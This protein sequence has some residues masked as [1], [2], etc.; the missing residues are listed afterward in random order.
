MFTEDGV[1]AKARWIVTAL[2][3]AAAVCGPAVGE[4]VSVL[5]EEGAYAQEVVGDLDRAIGIYRKVIEGEEGNRRYLAE[6]RYRL[7]RCYLAKGGKDQAREQFRKLVELYP[8]QKAF[9]KAARDELAKLAPAEAAGTYTFG[10]VTD[11]TVNDD[12]AG[13]DFFMDLD[14]GRLFS[15]P[16]GLDLH[17]T[18]AMRRWVREN[19][20]DAMG[21]T[22]TSVHGLVGIEMVAFPFA[23]PRWDSVTA[24]QLI[25]DQ[26]LGAAQPNSLVPISAKGDLPATYIFKTREGGTGILQIVGFSSDP[27]G[28]KIRYK[29]VQKVEAVAGAYGGE[30]AM[31]GAGRGTTGASLTSVAVHPYLPLH[32]TVDRWLIP[33]TGLDLQTGTILPY[34][35]RTPDT[36]WYRPPETEVESFRPIG[37]PLRAV[38]ADLVW[39]R[40]SYGLKKQTDLQRPLIWKQSPISREVAEALQEDVE[41]M[42]EHA[43]VGRA[44]EILNQVTPLQIVHLGR[45]DAGRSV[46]I[47]LDVRTAPAKALDYICDLAGL[48]WKADGSLVWIGTP[49]RIEHLAIVHGPDV[50]PTSEATEALGQP[51][52]L[53]LQSTPLEQVAEFLSHMTPVKVHLL[54]GAQALGRERSEVTIRADLPLAEALDAVCRLTGLAWRVD[55]S[56]VTIGTPREVGL[57]VDDFAEGL[58]GKDM[59]VLPYRRSA[60][61]ESLR[62]RLAGLEP[63]GKVSLVPDSGLPVRY[64]V[65]TASGTEAELEIMS[66]QLTEQGPRLHIRYELL[67]AGRGGERNRIP[68][69]RDSEDTL[70]PVV[71][72]PAKA[73]AILPVLKGLFASIY[74][75]VGRGDAQSAAKSL[76]VALPRV[77]ELHRNLVGTHAYEPVGLAIEQLELMQEALRDGN[78]DAAREVLDG[79][80]VSGPQLEQ[81]L[82]SLATREP[83]KDAASEAATGR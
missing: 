10:P 47:T 67:A 2:L 28:V 70:S 33:G 73:A 75:A 74:G 78:L 31:G 82:K 38:S 34:N 3:I 71:S 20:I 19:G 77:R 23:S 29:L 48:A 36:F 6:A 69:I 5:M 45:E 32:E 79:F 21:E 83:A 61:L 16:P 58:A 49:E 12:G 17:Q 25:G 44:L 80:N 11:L 57:L 54:A 52:A 8:E 64:V 53:M 43:A 7:G 27:H 39:D 1:M 26:T 30:G 62:S 50:D 60:D 68:L 22:S 42:L 14:R 18:D 46:M 81:M 63:Q 41:I 35:V 55:R 40:S 15:P 4:E 59:A 13:E 37:T 24:E 65:R 72:D 51:M 76:E 9:S 66:A 56:V